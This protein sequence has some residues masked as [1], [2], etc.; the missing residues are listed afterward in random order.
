M[1]RFAEFANEERALEGDKVRIDDALNKEIIV[2]AFKIGK[3]KYSKDETQRKYVTLQIKF[4][5]EECLK[6]IFT[7]SEVIADQ[8]EK[9]KEEMPFAT[10][11]KKVNNYYTFS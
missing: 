4:N 2:C 9:Y 5:G 8:C 1:K 11:I 10:V 6:V 7:G 3:S